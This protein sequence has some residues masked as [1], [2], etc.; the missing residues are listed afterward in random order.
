MTRESGVEPKGLDISI[1]NVVATASFDQKFDLR[2][3]MKAFRNA[4]YNPRR[5]PGLV[6]RLKRPKTSTLIFG[7]GKMVCT[8]AKSDKQA[9]SA[10]RKVVRELENEGFTLGKPLI[11]VQNM[12]ASVNLHGEVD[13]EAA[14][15][16]LENVM[17]EPS[18]FPAL[19]LRMRAPRVVILVFSSGKLVCT[20]AKTEGMVREAVVKLHGVLEDRGLLFKD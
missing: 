5:F 7:S 10:I 12:V 11:E 19:V 15:D 8:G 20:G 16:V 18:Q 13:L 9:G 14:A 2:A 3:I 17:Y 4:E 1:V 6:F